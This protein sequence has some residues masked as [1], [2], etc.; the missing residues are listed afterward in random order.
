MTAHLRITTDY[1][2]DQQQLYQKFLRN[3]DFHHSLSLHPNQICASI[4]HNSI[5]KPVLNHNFNEI[6]KFKNTTITNKGL[7]FS[8]SPI[9]Q[10]H[11]ERRGWPGCLTA[12][13]NCAGDW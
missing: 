5:H 13:G 6:F 3:L 10:L 8:P 9:I 7:G 4:Q 11:Q 12:G 2:M 1:E